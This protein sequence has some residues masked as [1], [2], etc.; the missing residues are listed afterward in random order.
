MFNVFLRSAH[1]KSI[2]NRDIFF[3][4]MH[5]ALAV[6]F[7]CSKVLLKEVDLEM[8]GEDNF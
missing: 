2:L 6:I 8:V 5:H 4:A 1:L 3:G 7:I